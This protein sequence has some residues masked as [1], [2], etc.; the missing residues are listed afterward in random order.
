MFIYM[1]V[2]GIKG[3]GQSP[4]SEGTDWIMLTNC[5]FGFQRPFEPTTNESEGD[6]ATKKKTARLPISI[7]KFSDRATPALASW[8]ASNDVRKVEIEFSLI[9]TISL[10]EFEVNGARLQSYEATYS[11]TEA[12]VT[13]TLSIE[14]ESIELLYWLQAAT[15]EDAGSASNFS[16]PKP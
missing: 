12:V 4:R 9:P 3:V 1:R 16:L 6:D 7:K 5:T 13:E 11:G 2:E 14:Y 8:R 15:N 10:I